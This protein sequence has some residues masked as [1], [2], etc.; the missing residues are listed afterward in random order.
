MTKEDKITDTMVIHRI[1]RAN[2]K[3]MPFG[4]SKGIDKFLDIYPLLK[5]NKEQINNKK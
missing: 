4:K 3:T 5:L 2:V 1:I